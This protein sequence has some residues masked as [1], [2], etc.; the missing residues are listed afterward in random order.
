MR[1]RANRA[2]SVGSRQAARLADFCAGNFYGA[3]Q[4]VF[5]LMLGVSTRGFAVT[6]NNMFDSD[7]DNCCYQG[8]Q[9]LAVRRALKDLGASTSDVFVDLGSGKGKALLIAGRLPYKHVVGIEVDREL[10]RFAARNIDRAQPRLRAGKV[11]CIN[12]DAAE[13][14]I[15]DDTSVVFMFNPFI[16]ET[17]S[18]IASRIF[19][20]YD[21][22]PRA[23]HIVYEH[24][25]EH[26]WLLSTRRVVVTD[27]RPS[28]SPGR[29][30]WWKGG[31][32]IVTY[33]VINSTTRN[34][35]EVRKASR[36]Y[37]SRRAIRRWS[38]PNNHN[39]VMPKLESGEVFTRF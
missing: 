34:K 7:T 22:N 28:T 12:A 13:W 31:D 36:L 25:W 19:E 5:D 11:E 14:P 17:F 39:F 33:E 20:S 27:V 10:S 38:A 29:L 21:H 4:R 32:V 37:R 3:Q 18:A 9:W 1:K 15:P 6:E 30:G 2:W 35:F 26:D 24:P 23:L 8:C 16:G